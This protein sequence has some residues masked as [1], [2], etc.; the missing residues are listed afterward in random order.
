MSKKRLEEPEWFFP[1]VG[2]LPGDSFFVPTNNTE[3]MT[4]KVKNAAK[5]FGM[6]VIIRARVE[7]AVLG[8]R[9]WRS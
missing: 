2:M 8:V 3:Y 5:R 7:D 9:V 4:Y 6:E 1:F